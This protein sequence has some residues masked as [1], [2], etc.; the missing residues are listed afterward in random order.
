MPHSPTTLIAAAIRKHYERNGHI[1]A[2]P[3]AEE[4]ILALTAGD[5]LKPAFAKSDRQIIEELH[6]F[7]TQLWIKSNRQ[8]ISEQSLR[9]FLS[10][11]VEASQIDGLLL[12]AQRSGVIEAA[13][14]SRGQYQLSGFIPKPMR[15]FSQE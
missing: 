4:I 5:L 15:D 9:D 12:K 13:E 8:P 2:D 7:A 6:Y 3:L 10:H 11:R 1:K 14:F